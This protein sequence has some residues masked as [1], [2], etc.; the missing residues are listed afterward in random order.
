LREF[1]QYVPV[2]DTIKM[3]WYEICRIG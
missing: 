3:D 1:V 2:L